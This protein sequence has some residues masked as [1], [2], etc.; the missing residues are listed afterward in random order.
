M[1]SGYYAAV[2]GAVSRMQA[3]DVLTNNLS[4]VGTTGF[5][6]SVVNFTS[7]LDEARQTGN[8][9]GINYSFVKGVVPDMSDG[10]AIETGNPLN[11]AIMGDGFFKVEG[12]DG[13]FYT[14]Q[15]NF[16]LDTNGT[17]ITPT[18]HKVIGEGGP[19]VL[20]SNDVTI[21]QDGQISTAEGAVNKIN[22]Y[23][24]ENMSQLSRVKDGV[25]KAVDGAQEKIVANPGILQGRLEASNVNV[26]QEMAQMVA[27][28]RYFESYEKVM[29]SY[30]ELAAKANQIGLLG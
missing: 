19:I 20:N 16:R 4:N 21:G 5:K 22:L 29:K 6:K 23:E 27:G 24:F 8:A 7:Y 9:E 17:L 3:M 11:M 13:F 28:V 30:S 14:R 15:G 10:T 1:S 18:G 25:F 2:S 12:E 26:L